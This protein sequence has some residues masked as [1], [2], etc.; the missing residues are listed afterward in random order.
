ME[1]L[2]AGLMQKL[3][4]L[5]KL[6]GQARKEILASVVVFPRTSSLQSDTP[7]VLLEQ[8][9]LDLEKVR[10]LVI[11]HHEIIAINAREDLDMV[12]EVLLELQD[13]LCLNHYDCIQIYRG[14]LYLLR[15]INT[16]R[17][18]G[19]SAYIEIN[20]YRRRLQQLFASMEPSWSECIRFALDMLALGLAAYA[21][22]KVASVRDK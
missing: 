14:G 7:L 19:Q 9:Q 8:D 15:I 17:K 3:D 16:S 20:D 6:A 21:L 4:V 2:A 11:T 13:E 12:L 1:E 5:M 10:A 22:W 18:V